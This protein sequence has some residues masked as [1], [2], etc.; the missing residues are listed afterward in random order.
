MGSVGV[1]FRLKGDDK[2]AQGVSPGCRIAEI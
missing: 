1:L 2:K